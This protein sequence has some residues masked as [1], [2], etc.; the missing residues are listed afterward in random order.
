MAERLDHAW[1]LVATAFSFAL[2][3]VV[4]LVLWGVLFPCLAPF[5]GASRKRHAHG[6]MREVF[7]FYV[8]LMGG[9]GLL[10]YEVR[11]GERLERPGRL[12]VANHPSLLDV[13]FLISLIRDATCVVK[14]ALVRN[15][16]MRIPIRAAQYLYADDPEGVLDQ[17]VRELREGASLIVFPEGTRTTPGQPRHF[18]RGAANIALAAGVPIV[19]VY[20]DCHPTTLTKYEKWYRIPERKV[21]YRFFVGAEFDPASYGTGQSRALASRSL[22]RRLY[23]Y[24]AEQDGIHGKP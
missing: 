4:G 19:P 8:N 18:R 6:L 17:C 14:P 20:I 22:T 23:E 9:F 24:F 7:R 10:S 16:F 12:V 5:L 15:P 11:D 13:V 1:R 3:G 21:S 2:F